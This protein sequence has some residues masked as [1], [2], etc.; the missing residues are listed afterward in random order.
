MILPIVAYGDP[1]LH[2]VAE[3]I[4]QDYPGLDALIENMYETMYNA[5]GV[6]LAAPQIGRGVRLFV[7]DASP[8]AEED[9]DDFELL[10]GLKKTFINPIIIEEDANA[11]ANT[12]P[13]S[14]APE[15]DVQ[16]RDR[17][18]RCV[19]QRVL[20]QKRDIGTSLCS[21]SALNPGVRVP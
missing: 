17:Q 4:D 12:S 16:R 5:Q 18:R 13:F 20:V 19:P 11:Q 8:F 6:G 21:G 9:S 14:S 7:I 3:E 2:K 15:L 10:S 1:V